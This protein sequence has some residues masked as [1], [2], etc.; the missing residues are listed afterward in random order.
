MDMATSLPCVNQLYTMLSRWK[1]KL[2][3]VKHLYQTVNDV[4]ETVKDDESD[5]AADD[6]LVQTPELRSSEAELNKLEPIQRPEEIPTPRH[7]ADDHDRIEAYADQTYS[8]E[9][10]L[11]WKA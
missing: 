8:A 4:T 7:K 1:N 10:T 6:K 9:Q 3:G 5:E 2:P 11:D